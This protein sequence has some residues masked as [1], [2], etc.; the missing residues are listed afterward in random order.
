MVVIEEEEGGNKWCYLFSVLN[1]IQTA[2]F[3]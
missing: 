1:F 2:T 3:G